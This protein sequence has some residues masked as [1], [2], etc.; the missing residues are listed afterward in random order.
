MNKRATKLRPWA[1]PWSWEASAS[2]RFARC[3][4][5]VNFVWLPKT[6][7]SVYL[8]SFIP[9]V[10]PTPFCACVRKFPSY[11]P[12]CSSFFLSCPV[13]SSGLL[14]FVFPSF[15]YPSPLFMSPF[16][17]LSACL[18]ILSFL[19]VFCTSLSFSFSL[20]TAFVPPFSFPSFFQPSLYSCLSFGQFLCLFLSFQ[21]F[22]PSTLPFLSLF[23]L[24]TSFVSPFSFPSFLYSSLPSFWPPPSS[25]RW[26]CR[27]FF[28]LPLPVV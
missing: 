2:C 26:L 11:L 1:S 27:L 12:A 23:L 14:A 18:L 20:N 4:Q 24:I 13:P 22:L 8:P 16:W 7:A 28:P 21:P 25:F 19:L 5:K 10:P 6:P 17:S 9:F 3:L 15:I